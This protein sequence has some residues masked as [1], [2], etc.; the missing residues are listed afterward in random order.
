MR[1]PSAGTVPQIL[2]DELDRMG[3]TQQQLA[4]LLGERDNW[5]S[6]RLNGQTSITVDELERIA[7]AM[8]WSAADLFEQVS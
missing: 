5:L 3:M 8:G 2:R 6:R 4:R 1:P 7:A